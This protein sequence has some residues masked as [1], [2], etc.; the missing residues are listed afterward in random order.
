MRLIVKDLSFSYDGKKNLWEGVSFTV[1][2]GDIFSIMGA[3]GCGKST[4]IRCLI[5]FLQ[6]RSGDVY[7]EEEDG[8]VFDIRN[9]PQ[10]FTRRIGYV[11]QIQNTAYSYSVQD[12]VVM[13]RAPH[14]GLFQKPSAEDYA[15]AAEL[16]KELNIYEIRERPLN[17]LSGGQQR[18]AV[19]ARAIIQEPEMVIMDEPTNH[20]DYGNQYRVMDMIQRLAE[21]GI[22]VLLTTHMPDHAIHLNGPVAMM[23]NKTVQVGSAEK[24]ITEENLAALYNLKVYIKEIPELNRRVCV[25]EKRQ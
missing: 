17:M 10:E 2:K 13:G 6:P 5:G 20:L 4:L 11:P 24:I 1:E 18:Q 7:L 23:L 19:I 12:Y 3:N 14:L 8:S 15:R 22:A 25:A 16:L 21:R 9:N